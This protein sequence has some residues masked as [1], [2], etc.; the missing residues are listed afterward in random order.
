[1]RTSQL[2]YTVHSFEEDIGSVC[3]LI[4]TNP[5][6]SVKELYRNYLHVK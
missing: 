4:D 3:Y 6:Y 1:M 2:S 5:D